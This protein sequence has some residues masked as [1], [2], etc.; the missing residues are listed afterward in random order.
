V[1]R[2]REASA[3]AEPPLHVHPGW[4]ER[5][6]WLIQGTTGRGA[7]AEPWDLGLFGATPVREAHARWR[8]LRTTLG[9][10]GAVHA[11][12]VHGDRV[13]AHAAGPPGLLVADDADGHVTAV[14]GLLLT[15]SVADCVPIFLV[16]PGRRAV[17]LLHGGWRGVAAGILERGLAVL[18]AQAGSDAAGLWLHCGPAICGACYEVGPEVFRALGEAAPAAPQPIDLRA[19]IGRRA[20]ALGL[21]A[22]RI[23]VSEHCTRCGGGA[24]FSHRAGCAE[25]QLGVLAVAA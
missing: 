19:H 21:D 6:P 22:D 18:A 12:Q 13:L 16:D 2:V 7:A 1:Q 10:T 11:R 4:R 8:A 25:R 5:F 3:G 23:S 20:R 15:V 14:P 9:C 24:F 17:A